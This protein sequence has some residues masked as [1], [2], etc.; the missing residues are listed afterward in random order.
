[1]ARV[2]ARGFSI[3][4]IV[5]RV[6]DSFGASQLCLTQTPMCPPH[7]LNKRYPTDEVA[8]TPLLD[9]PLPKPCPSRC[10]VA[11]KPILSFSSLSFVHCHNG[12][13]RLLSARMGSTF[14]GSDNLRP[15]LIRRLTP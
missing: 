13:P 14:I 5:D 8:G 4:A 1:M 7:L 11:E 9:V 3:V 12:K 15:S 10:D 6:L 2:A